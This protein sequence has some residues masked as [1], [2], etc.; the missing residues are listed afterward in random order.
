MYWD[1]ILINHDEDNCWKNSYYYAQK[2]GADFK[3]GHLFAMLA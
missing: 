1:F 2:S 3:E